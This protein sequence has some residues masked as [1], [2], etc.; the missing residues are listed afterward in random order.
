M[1]SK[2]G[3]LWSFFKQFFWRQILLTKESLSPKLCGNRNTS[4]KI[5]FCLCPLLRDGVCACGR[6]G[7][8]C[9]AGEDSFYGDA[10]TESPATRW[11]RGR[12]TTRGGAGG[13]QPQPA[14]PRSNERRGSGKSCTPVATGKGFSGSAHDE[15]ERK[16]DQHKSVK[17]D[18]E[19]GRRSEPP[20]GRVRPGASVEYRRVRAGGGR[21]GE[22]GAGTSVPRPQRGIAAQQSSAAT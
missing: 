10:A 11:G 16:E 5:L 15:G 21:R 2:L 6:L 18:G 19:Q 1:T 8:G 20:Q 17:F 13:R 12:A 3:Y 4:K 9:T 7:P 14:A 22:N